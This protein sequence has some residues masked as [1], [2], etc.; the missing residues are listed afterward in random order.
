MCVCDV[1]MIIGFMNVIVLYYLCML[2]NMG[3]V[4]YYKK[5]KIVFY[6][7]VSNYVYYFM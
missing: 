1:V 4:E 5:G 6:R 3:F 7:L 2:C